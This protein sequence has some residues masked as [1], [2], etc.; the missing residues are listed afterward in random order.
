MS[1]FGE[2][3]RRIIAAR[4]RQ[5]QRQVNA[6]LLTLDDE[7]LRAGGYDRKELARN[8]SSAINL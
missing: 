4:Q 6:T 8:A 3:G 7:I 5:A 1:I 2:F